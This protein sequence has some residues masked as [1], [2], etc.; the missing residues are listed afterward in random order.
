MANHKR[1]SLRY[2]NLG[3]RVEKSSRAESPAISRVCRLPGNYDA[4]AQSQF[5]FAARV[6]VTVALARLVLR[7]SSSSITRANAS[8]G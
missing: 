8:F 4:A 2:S 1:T 3:V 5:C 6:M 7:A